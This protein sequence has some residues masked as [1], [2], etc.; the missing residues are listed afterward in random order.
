MSSNILPI[1]IWSTAIKMMRPL[2]PPNCIIWSVWVVLPDL[3]QREVNEA[4]AIL[5]GPYKVTAWVNDVDHKIQC[6]SR[7]KVIVVHPHRPTLYLGEAWDRQ[8]WG[9][10]SVLWSEYGKGVRF[11]LCLFKSHCSIPFTYSGCTL[12]FQRTR[13]DQNPMRM[14]R[15][16]DARMKVW[17]CWVQ[18]VS[19]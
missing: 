17:N 2:W 5:T 4:A 12:G 8:P 14:F 10:S 11:N 15:N 7:V 6:H 19:S 3:D 18:P 1:S 16:D 9:R 13:V